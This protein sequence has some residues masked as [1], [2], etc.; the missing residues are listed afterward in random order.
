MT[1]K[2]CK[3]CDGRGWYLYDVPLTHRLWNTQVAC[4]CEAGQQ[5]QSDIID[6]TYAK[7]G[8]SDLLRA[9]T[10][11]YLRE[12]RWKNGISLSDSQVAA[13]EFA[14]NNVRQGGRSACFIG[15][16]GTGKTAL[17][18]AICNELLKPYKAV[19]LASQNYCRMDVLFLTVPDLLDHLRATFSPTSD[20]EYD[21]LFER[22]KAVKVLV[23]DDLGKQSTT[24]WAKEKLYQ[25]INYRYLHRDNLITLITSNNTMDEI[26][27]WHPAIARRVH[28][29]C[30]I[31]YVAGNDLGRA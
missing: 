11:D 1:T 27:D 21:D 25:I 26:A 5:R 2:P 13:L 30:H 18:A 28:E 31:I 19:E 15:D 4:D 3:L 7:S 17:V 22:I 29:M 12:R 24:D 6:R 20:V 14:E 9:T 10:F 8:M 23:L 16:Y